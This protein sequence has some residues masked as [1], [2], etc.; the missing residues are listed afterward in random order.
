MLCGRCKKSIKCQCCG[1][2]E[3]SDHVH[4][5]H[6]FVPEICDCEPIYIKNIMW[7]IKSII[8]I[9]QIALFFICGIVFIIAFF[10]SC[11]LEN[12]A[13]ISNILGF[14]MC[15]G[16]LNFVCMLSCDKRW[17]ED[18]IDY[19]TDANIMKERG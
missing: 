15:I 13:W 5:G 11:F 17:R 18:Y 9:I 19:S 6:K 16:I 12:T 14:S 10:F 8:E 7:Y 2:T 4:D 3:Y 1:E